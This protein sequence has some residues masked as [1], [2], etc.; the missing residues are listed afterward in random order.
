MNNG[1]HSFRLWTLGTL[2]IMVTLGSMTGILLR[3]WRDGIDGVPSGNTLAMAAGLLLLG[4]IG[5]WFRN[6]HRLWVAARA[7]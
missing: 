7:R 5:V 1:R 4:L 3:Q 2:V 6:G